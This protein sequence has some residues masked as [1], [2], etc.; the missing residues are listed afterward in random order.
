MPEKLIKLKAKERKFEK[1]LYEKYNSRGQESTLN[2]KEIALAYK[3]QSGIE[4]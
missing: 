1:L 4:L 2:F 3:T